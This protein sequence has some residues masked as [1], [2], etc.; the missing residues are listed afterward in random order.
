MTLFC[1]ESGLEKKS[2]VIFSILFIILGSIEIWK[3][4]TPNSNIP[5]EM[6]FLQNIVIA[7]LIILFIF[8]NIYLSR[9]YGITKRY[10][11]SFIMGFMFVGLIY[12]VLYEKVKLGNIA[13]ELFDTET[14][15]G[16]KESQDI[17]LHEM[18]ASDIYIHTG[19]ITRYKG[20]IFNPTDE[21]IEMRKQVI[22]IVKHH[23]INI[24][25]MYYL[26][27]LVLVSF[28]LGYYIPLPKKI[29][30]GI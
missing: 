24:H 29:E 13:I 22:E 19:E 30:Q 5:V 25:M 3:N 20:V 1:K 14:F 11:F 16:L 4:L 7:F 21:D 26:A 12:F 10:I 27:V 23:N 9:I 28:L 2:D 18:R 17:R 15:I 8:A 6:I